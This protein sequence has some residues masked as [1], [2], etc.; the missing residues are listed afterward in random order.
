LSAF[1]IAGRE[2]AGGGGVQ[3]L[4]L[5]AKPVHTGSQGHLASPICRKQGGEITSHHLRFA[6][7]EHVD[8]IL[9][10][11]SINRLELPITSSDPKRGFR[12]VE[13]LITVVFARLESFGVSVDLDGH[14]DLP[15]MGWVGGLPS[16]H[17]S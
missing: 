2:A 1:Q 3:W 13:R 7:T 4:L 11:R 17:S 15:F 14:V 10:T 6:F 8:Q 12:E 5:N 9:V 16:S